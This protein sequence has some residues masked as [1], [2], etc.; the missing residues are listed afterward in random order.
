MT[1][2]SSIHL[3][4]ALVALVAPLTLVDRAEAF[5]PPTTKIDPHARA[6]MVFVPGVAFR[7]AVEASWAGTIPGSSAYGDPAGYDVKVAS[8]YIDRTEVTVGAY[9]AC[10]QSGACAALLDGDNFAANHTIVCTYG[11]PGLEQHPVNCVS[12]VEAEKYCAYQ[13]KRLPTEYEFELAERGPNGK[14]FPWGDEPPTPRH[15]NAC[16][17]ACARESMAKLNETFTS[18]WPSDPLA[19]DGFPFTAPVGSY[20]AG[21]SPFG[22]LDMS[23]NVEEWVDDAWWDLGPSGPT[24]GPS[25][26]NDYVVRGGSW[27]L[28]SIDAFATTRRT[29]AAGTTRA[30]WLGFRCAK[31]G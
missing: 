8:F 12:H 24:K 5:V 23:G 1:R 25:V 19:D 18:L 26:N 3:V 15:V 2:A 20:P 21:A 9:T 10:V 30:A 11:K 22:A 17:A 28:N 31:D 4:A 7:F 13:N 16:D 6:D 27:D 14:P 29:D